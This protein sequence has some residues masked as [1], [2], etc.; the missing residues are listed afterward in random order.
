MKTLNSFLILAVITTAAIMLSFTGCENVANNSVNSDTYQARSEHD[1][2]ANRDLKTR[3]GAVIA[4]HLEDVNSTPNDSI[5]DTGTIGMDV[6][7]IRYVENKVHTFRMESTA[8]FDVNMFNIETGEWMFYMSPVYTSI[9]VNIPAG[10]YRME[11]RSWV[12]YT[13][14]SLV[15]R[16]T[17]F[18]QPEGDEY[19][20][21]FSLA[22]CPGCDLKLVNLSYMFLNGMNFSRANFDKANL[23]YTNFIG[24]NLSN[25]SLKA[26]FFYKSKLQYADISGSSAK[27]VGF[28]DSNLSN[29]NITGSDLTNCDLRFSDISFVNFC[30]STLTGIISDGVIYN[31]PPQCW[32]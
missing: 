8:R 11:I 26:A 28:R 24:S 25:T 9:T 32:P 14:D 13:Y 27:E 22:G 17:I 4:V 18:I 12:D 1:F 5:P 29:A 23:A 20:T 3:P 21:F 31:G 15:G 19:H 6:I 7:P 10:D 2:V 30:G 16:Q